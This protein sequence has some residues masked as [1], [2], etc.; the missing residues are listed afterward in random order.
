MKKKFYVLFIAVAMI[1]AMCACGGSPEAEPEEDQPSDAPAETVEVSPEYAELAEYYVFELEGKEYSL[2]CPISDFTDNGW[3]VDPADLNF[4]LE[5]D[6]ISSVFVY[7]DSSKSKMAFSLILF[8]TSEETKAG[9]NCLVGKIE[10]NPENSCTSMTLKKA[11]VT[12]D[13]SSAEAAQQSMELLTE[14]YGTDDGVYNNYDADDAFDREWLLSYKIAG[15]A[16]TALAKEGTRITIP[17]GDSERSLSFSLENFG[18]EP[19]E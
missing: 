11:G 19:Q 5:K 9:E 6:Y 12:V 4:E 16:L 3:Y 14:A 8:N 18:P 13:V 17:K 15:K 10:L 2:P 1:F 7:T